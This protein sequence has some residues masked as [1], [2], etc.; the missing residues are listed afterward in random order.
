MTTIRRFATPEPTICAV[1][2]RRAVWIGF[3]PNNQPPIWLC[4]TTECSR[5]ARQ[6]YTMKTY[7]LDAYEHGARIE[8]S[9]AFGAYIEECGTTDLAKLTEEQWDE[10]WTRAILTYEKAM[11]RKIQSN[12]TP[13]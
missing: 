12:E 2:R 13:F 8:A 11:I 3:S 6:V 7:I 10:G 5:L 1:C 4:G 9:Q